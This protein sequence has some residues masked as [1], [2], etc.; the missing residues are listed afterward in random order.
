MRQLRKL[1][2]LT[3][4]HLKARGGEIGKLKQVYFDDRRWVV[5]YLVVQTGSWLLGKDVLIIPSMIN[6]V[7]EEGQQIVVNLSCDQVRKSPPINTQLP[8]SRYYEQEYFRYYDG[9]PYWSVDPVFNPMSIIPPPGEGE[10]P[11]QP[12]NPHLRSSDEV[13]GYRLHSQDGEIGHVEDFILDD[14]DWTIR[15]LEIDTGHWLP[16]KKVLLSPAWLQEID[17]T[18]NE[19]SVDLPTELIKS[20]PE[21]APDKVISRDYQLALYK[22]YGK[23]IVEE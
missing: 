23:A 17:F 11:K 16:G 8:V 14:Q 20:A 1:K 3:G 15:Y 19:I 5:R 21:Y 4:Y 18:R 9:Q 6:A 12:K 10:L 22:H 7:A 2:K 13:Q